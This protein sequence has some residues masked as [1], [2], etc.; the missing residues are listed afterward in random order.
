MCGL[1]LP[2]FV[3]EKL[4]EAGKTLQKR[5]K[6]KAPRLIRQLEKLEKRKDSYPYACH[7]EK[8]RIAREF[9]RQVFNDRQL[10]RLFPAHLFTMRIYNDVVSRKSFTDLPMNENLLQ[11]IQETLRDTQDW[12]NIADTIERRKYSTYPCAWSMHICQQVSSKVLVRGKDYTSGVDIRLLSKANL[13]AG[14]VHYNLDMF[15]AGPA[16]CWNRKWRRLDGAHDER[17]G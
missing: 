9:L 11:Q 10:A 8:E 5:V 13:D 12:Q 4:R 16:N 3:E 2:K 1:F 7:G 6:A 14:F 17:E 15:A